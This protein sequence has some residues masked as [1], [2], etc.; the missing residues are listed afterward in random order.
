MSRTPLMWKIMDKNEKED[1]WPKRAIGH[2]VV[3]LD[4]INKYILI[5]GNFDAYGNMMKNIEL[6]T[7]LIGGIDKRIESFESLSQDKIKYF[8]ESI[9]NNFKKSIDVFLY[10]PGILV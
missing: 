1:L 6:N 3:Y 10:D 2:S 7:K 4:D 5:G 9:A 8:N